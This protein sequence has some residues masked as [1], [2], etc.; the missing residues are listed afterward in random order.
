LV[1]LIAEPRYT[2]VHEPATSKS[3]AW[4]RRRRSQASIHLALREV[5]LD[6]NLLELFIVFLS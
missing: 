2:T 1:L 5:P 6:Q 4:E 3:R